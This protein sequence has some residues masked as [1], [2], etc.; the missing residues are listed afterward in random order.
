MEHADSAAV[1]P[2]DTEARARVLHQDDAQPVEI[3]KV[4]AGP[5]CPAADVLTLAVTHLKFAPL[6]TTLWLL[7]PGLRRPLAWTSSRTVYAASAASLG[8][9]EPYVA[10]SPLELEAYA[11]AFERDRARAE[12]LAEHATKKLRAPTWRLTLAIALNG[13]TPPPSRQPRTFVGA[14]ELC[15]AHE[16]RYGP[17]L[18]QLAHHFGARL[19]RVDFDEPTVTAAR[20]DQGEAA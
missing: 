14:S 10:F 1:A 15:P 20:T 3:A 5:T 19:E 11:T 2:L 7:V 6:G 17:T 12:D 18:G 9:Q 13:A 8:S 4:F 16:A